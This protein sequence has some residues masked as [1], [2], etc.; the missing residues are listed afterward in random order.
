MG[1]SLLTHAQ[2]PLSYWS[3]AFSTASYLINRLP[4]PTLSKKSPYHCLFGSPPNYLKLHSFGCL[5]YSWL[6]PYTPHKLGPKSRTCIFIGYSKTQCA[7]HCLDPTT[8]CVFTSR[9]VRFIESEFPISSLTKLDSTATIPSPNSWCQISLPILQNPV[10]MPTSETHDYFG[11][12]PITS[13]YSNPPCS[14]STPSND[15]ST[16]T[17]TNPSSSIN[18]NNSTP[19][20]VDNI[21]HASN[22]TQN[23]LL[24]PYQILMQA[25]LL[26]SNL[27]TQYL[28]LS[29]GPKTTFSSL[30]KNICTLSPLNA[31]QRS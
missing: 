7:Y 26:L 27:L 15:Q 25:Q 9:H 20:N 23:I 24:H 18:S 16:P 10:H 8:N 28:V 5:C 14:S 2:L 22:P 30:I 29:H 11:A 3:F 4:T 21:H 31:N 17:P 12:S 13:T 19:P 6:K 1:L